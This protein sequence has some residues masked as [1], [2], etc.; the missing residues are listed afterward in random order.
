MPLCPKELADQSGLNYRTI[1]RHIKNGH[2][3]AKRLGPKLWLISDEAAAPYL[4]K[5]AQ[6]QKSPRG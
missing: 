1:I 3:K 2:L 4:P 5:P 6:T